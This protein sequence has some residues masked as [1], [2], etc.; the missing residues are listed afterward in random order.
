MNDHD[1]GLQIATITGAAL[2][3]QLEVSLNSVRTGQVVLV[4]NIEHGVC[5]LYNDREMDKKTLNKVMMLI[6]DQH[7]KLLRR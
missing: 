5:E 1:A 6:Q 2:E 3:R 7:A 4:K